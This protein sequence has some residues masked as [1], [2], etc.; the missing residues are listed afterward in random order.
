MR[1]S[2]L[3][4]ILLAATGWAQLVPLSQVQILGNNN[5]PH[6]YFFRNS[7]SLA[8]SGKYTYAQWAAIFD[9]L[10]GIEGK[11]LGEEIPNRIQNIPFFT[12][13]KK[14]H[15]DQLVLLH[16][17][18]KGREPLFDTSQ[19]FPGHWLY[20]QGSSVTADVPAQQGT[21][22]IQVANGTYFKM[23]Q[24]VYKDTG[25]DIALCAANSNGTPNWNQCEQVKLLSVTSNTLQV[26]RGQY[27]TTPLSFTAG[28]AWAAAHYY[29]GPSSDGGDLLW[30][31][32]YSTTCPRDS[33]GRS[34]SDVLKEN[35]AQ[36]FDP[37][38]DL[39]V[40]DGLEFDVM[41][42]TLP[43]IPK[44]R[45][46]DA[47]GDGQ[48]DGGIFNGV[49]Q[50]GIGMIEFC[51]SFRQRMGPNR[52]ILA[53]GQ[54]QTNQRAF[55]IMNGVESEGWPVLNDL[56][57]QDW[58]G[59]T[60]RLNFWAANS[61]SPAWNYINHKFTTP[62]TNGPGT[63]AQVPFSID[64]LVFA[65]AMMLNDPVT[66]S[67]TPT[68][69]TGQAVGIWDE[70][71]MGVAHKIGWLG[72]PLGPA[73]RLALE[74]P[75][76]LAGKWSSLVVGSGMTIAPDGN[77]LKIFP[78]ASTATQIQFQVQNVPTP[79]PD[80]LLTLRAHAQ[81]RSA[82][83]SSDARLLL[84][85]QASSTATQFMSFV[86]STSFASTFYFPGQSGS[87]L[88]FQATLEGSEPMWIDSISAYAYP[89]AMVRQ[90]ENGIVMVNP[91]LQPFTF[92]LSA[93]APRRAFHRFQGSPH[94]DPQTNDGSSVGASVTLASK[95]GLFLV[96]LQPAS[97][98][99]KRRQ[100]P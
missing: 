62:Q 77:S 84:L 16:F 21:T 86:N 20:F 28:H 6:A 56:T 55:G 98:P 53:D 61:F 97:G 46:I 67:L 69:E 15:P 49:N 68:P 26:Q 92:N 82:Y 4:C 79:G 2:G 96:S 95:D 59:G 60:N 66:F 74:Q 22:A 87:T 71:V 14:D 78:T 99:K 40:L 64:R 72:Q 8:A 41:F 39:E 37:G 43:S 54:E 29:D 42:D 36:H 11:C 93:L 32:N 88:N 44:Y 90:F 24:G 58:S 34:C 33:Q 35:L 73:R 94:Q 76:L 48:P 47:D 18:G 7:E 13:F 91:A 89:D 65:V 3:L 75:D 1:R 30:G 81:P 12:Q 19:F 38:G 80:L 23:G 45:N 100:R 63:I 51:Q 83:P 10:M 25:D 31:Y 27:G 57:I 9:Q 52:F 85:G 50:F 5:W 17:N 70:F